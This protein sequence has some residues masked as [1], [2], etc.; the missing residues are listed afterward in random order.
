MREFA[1]RLSEVKRPSSV[2][3]LNLGLQFTGQVKRKATLGCRS[4]RH[5]NPAGWTKPM[6]CPLGTAPRAC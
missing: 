6:L 1:L 5:S 4:S 3:K 2:I